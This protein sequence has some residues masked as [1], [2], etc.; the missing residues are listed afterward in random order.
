MNTRSTQASVK[1]RRRYK[2]ADGQS[3]PGVTTVTGLLNKPS[4]VRWANRLGLEGIDASAYTEE[5]AR[6]GTLVHGMIQAELLGQPVEADSVKP[7][8]QERAEAFLACFHAWRE[9]HS[10]RPV[11][12]ETAFVSEALRYGGTVDCYCYLDGRP[13]LLDFKTGKSIYEEYF[14]QLAAY[15]QLLREQGYPVEE[16]KVL[17]LSPEA[18]A[19]ER[20]VGDTEKWFA[21]FQHLLSIYY[22]KKD[23]GWRS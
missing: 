1:L 3:V 12:C 17:R 10:L 2:C 7:D 21:V 18:A 11:H 14:V 13:V 9:Q 16:V 6:L 5:S 8:D 15:A 20:S 19:Q 23:L 22:L 4:L